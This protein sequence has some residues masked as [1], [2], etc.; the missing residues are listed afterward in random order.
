MPNEP[1]DP[2]PARTP[3]LEPGGGVAPGDTPP[4]AESTTHAVTSREAK[5]PSRR[6]NMVI[7]AVTVVLLAA[8]GLALLVARIY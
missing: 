4:A 8:V 2:D 3:G 1:G 7:A 5:L 6:T